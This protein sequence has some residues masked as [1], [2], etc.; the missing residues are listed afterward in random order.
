MKSSKN[1]KGTKKTNATKKIKKKKK[2]FKAKLLKFIFIVMA[3]F[4]ILCAII[5]KAMTKP[6]VIPTINE[7]SMPDGTTVDDLFIDYGLR[8][9]EG[10]ADSDRK[11]EFYTFIIIGMDKNTNTDTIMVAS[12]DGINNEANVISIPRDSKVNVN[13]KV[14]KINAAYGA[15]TQKGRGEQGGIN[16][17]KKEIK[18]IIGFVPDFYIC[19]DVDAFVKIVD[20]VSGIEV[21]VPIDMKYDDPLQNLHIDLHKGSQVL[22][23]ENA[24][25]FARY[26]KGNNGKSISDYQRIENQQLVI[27][28]MVDRLLNPLILTKI[29]DFIKIFNENISSDIKPQ[30]M[31]W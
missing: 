24:L 16:Q 19:I 1:K 8:A 26:R 20:A 14:K 13:R 10:F 30:D 11:E 23:G 9:P 3:T 2:T 6:P 4:V 29:P 18:T 25:T 12:Y 28:A 7:A 17:L 22:N 5:L 15:G 31:L 27:K 21:D